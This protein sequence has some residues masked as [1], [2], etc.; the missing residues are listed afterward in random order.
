MFFFVQLYLINIHVKDFCLSAEQWS[1]LFYGNMQ[2]EFEMA[3]IYGNTEHELEMAFIC[4][5]FRWSF[6]RAMQSFSD[7]AKKYE[8][9]PKTIEHIAGFFEFLSK[10]NFEK[11]AEDWHQYTAALSLLKKVLDFLIYLT[12]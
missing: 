8:A 4:E 2:H 12:K 3:L 1:Y 11:D 9:D 5:K 7:V 10:I 6:S